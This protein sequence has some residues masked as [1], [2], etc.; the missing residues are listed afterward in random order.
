MP[1]NTERALLME[2]PMS[3]PEYCKGIKLGL[4]PDKGGGMW[5]TRLSVSLFIQPLLHHPYVM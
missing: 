2:M 1:L 5:R 4:M 3:S